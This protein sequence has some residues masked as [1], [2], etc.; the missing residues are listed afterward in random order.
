MS[1]HETSEYVELSLD[2]QTTIPERR[3]KQIKVLAEIKKQK[4]S[5]KYIDLKKSFMMM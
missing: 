5:L 4:S 2:R 1:I 3:Q